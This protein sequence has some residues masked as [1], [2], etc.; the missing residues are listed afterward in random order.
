MRGSP[1]A[2]VQRY[3][4]RSGF[5]RLCCGRR[6]G[7]RRLPIRA[8]RAGSA[9][10]LFA[11]L[12]AC[13]GGGGPPPDVIVSGRVTFDWVPAVAGSGL[14]YARTEARPARGVTVEVLEGTAMLGSTV[15]DDNGDYA[16]SVAPN[17]SV[18]VRVKAQMRRTGGPSWDFRVVDN[19]NGNALYVLDG[20]EFDT[21]TNAQTRNLHAG[22]GWTG[23]A[24]TDPRAAAP[25]AILD[26]IRDGVTLVLEADSSVDF[27]ALAVHWSPDN[28]PSPGA[29]GDPDPATGEIVT[30]FY[31]RS[32]GG[33]FALGA[34]DTDTDEYD[35]HVILHEWGHYLED[36]LWRT[37]SIGGPHQRGDALDMRV[38]FSEGWG[39]AF[40]ALATGESVYRDTL[41]V[42]QALAP[43]FDVEG[44]RFFEPQNPKPGWFSEESIQEL[45]YDL[46]DDNADGADALA[47]D[48]AAVYFALSND[49]ANAVAL[50]SV[51][52]FINALRLGNPAADPLIDAI[53]TDQSID[54]ILDDYASGETNDAGTVGGDVLPVYTPIV[55]NAPTPENLCSTDEFRGFPSG[56][57]NK[58]GSRRYLRFTLGAAA[59]LTFTARATDVPAGE[60]ADPDLV[61]H[62]A[63]VVT[64]SEDSPDA[65][66]TVSTPLNCAE[67]FTQM[68]AAGDYVLEAYE[69]TNTQADGS[70]FPPIG[71]TCFDVTVTQP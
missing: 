57:R 39:N 20:A 65:A 46:V 63:G 64:I 36:R 56:M 44:P 62:R 27:P 71:R 19:T 41:G 7:R 28:I 52:P 11:A 17:R 6:R 29:S 50:T 48:F 1:A 55:I 13:H 26:A 32:L 23:A 30:T 59:S 14:D 5:R 60:I 38:A 67:T 53:V 70:A 4:M 12:S 40:S 15:T 8:W 10:A 61:L 37:D 24:Y 34:A 45:I 69:F 3:V 35:R 58:L 33:I 54:S 2:R 51:F 9:W 66:C 22:S 16:L 49:V 42:Q 25:F 21:G 68:V 18:F 43:G 47:M 31:S